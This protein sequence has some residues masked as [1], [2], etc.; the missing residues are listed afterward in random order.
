MR[1]WFQ[2]GSSCEALHFLS[3]CVICRHGGTELSECQ[4]TLRHCW[5]HASLHVG[6]KTK[7]NLKS[8]YH[9]LS[10]RGEWARGYCVCWETLGVGDAA[11]LRYGQ[12]TNETFGCRLFNTLLSLMF[13]F[14]CSQRNEIAL[15]TLYVHAAYQAVA[16]TSGA[17]VPVYLKCVFCKLQIKFFSMLH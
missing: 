9:W 7:T 10:A 17:P 11:E 5:R 12:V 1:R 14:I 6:R 15:N 8:L 16:I 2:S 3:G 4:L 13:R